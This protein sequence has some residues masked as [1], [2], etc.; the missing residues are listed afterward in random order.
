[1]TTPKVD[2]KLVDELAREL[3][4]SLSEEERT[5]FPALIGGFIGSRMALAEA[6]DALP[7][8]PAGRKWW[9]PG[10]SEN[11]LNAWYVRTELRE[12][13]D[14]P[15]AGLRVA[16][17][18]NVMVAGVP[19]L[20]GS[21]LF[22]DYVAEV[23][24]TVVTRLLEAGAIIGGKAH[25][26]NFCLSAS[27][28]TGAGGYV[29]NPHD[30][31]RTSGGSSSGSG[32]LVGAGQV[33]LA[34]GGDQGGSIRVPAAYCGAVGMKPTHGLVPY[35]GAAPLDPYIDHLGPMTPDVR[36]NARMLEVLAGPD[37][38]DGRQSGVAAGE[39][40][41]ALDQGASGLRVG[42]LSEGFGVG[43][44]AV[45]GCVRAAAERLRG[46]GCRVSEI[47]VPEHRTSLA[48]PLMMEGTWRTVLTGDGLGTGRSDLYVSSYGERVRNWRSEPDALPIL[49]KL[50]LLAGHLV[51]RDHGPS[52]YGKAVNHARRLQ[53]TYDAAL[54]G[55][56]CLLM[57]TTPAIAPL[58][59]TSEPSVPE[60]F[61]LAASGISNTMQFDISH[62]PALSVPCGKVMDMPVGMMLVGRSYD[63]ATLYRIAHAFEDSVDWRTL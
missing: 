29:R 40:V 36:R 12:R 11:P 45:D 54:E 42:L 22:R 37:G 31:A 41:A 10:A 53:A 25:C 43:D 62:H 4:L 6:D 13:D 15:L 55:L 21:S 16:V 14:G 9:E 30:P 1:M 60:N 47:S 24:A 27:S 19:M 3:G 51:A 63:E 23:D 59:P 52:L 34:V 5:A 28:H 61:A 33:D 20:N 44:E 8:A 7:E 57:P 26:E 58:L 38:I 18:D 49:V 32:A 2:E 17:K 50:T 56:D 46:L 35:T 39:Y 48:V